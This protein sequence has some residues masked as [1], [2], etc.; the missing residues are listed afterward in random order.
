MGEPSRWYFVLVSFLGQCHRSS[1]VAW[2]FGNALSV[3]QCQGAFG[4]LLH[5]RQGGQG[6][7]FGLCD[8]ELVL[9]ASQSGA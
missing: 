8:I 1:C 7:P 3:E 2:G 9:F 6:F 4:I 5:R